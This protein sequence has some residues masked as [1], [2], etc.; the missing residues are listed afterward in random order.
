MGELWWGFGYLL[1]SV[2]YVRASGLNKRRKQRKIRTI[3]AGD[4]IKGP[5]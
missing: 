3:T 2:S 5:V 1:E 4:A